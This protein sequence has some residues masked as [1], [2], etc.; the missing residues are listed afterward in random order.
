M[1]CNNIPYLKSIPHPP[2]RFTSKKSNPLTCPTR[3]SH[4]LNQPINQ[5]S[6]TISTSP[7]YHIASL[8]HFQIISL[9]HYFITSFSNYL[10]FKLTRIT[11]LSLYSKSNLFSNY[12]IFKLSYFRTFKLNKNCSYLDSK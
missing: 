5:L 1:I 7:H 4:P 12:L 6:V 10:I 8:P 2:C 9:A 11:P 3:K